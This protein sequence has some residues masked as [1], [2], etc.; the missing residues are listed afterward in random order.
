MRRN[1]RHTQLIASAL[2][3]A[4]SLSFALPMVAQEDEEEEEEIQAKLA[5][6]LSAKLE[7]LDETA[8]D[9]ARAK[10]ERAINLGIGELQTIIDWLGSHAS[11]IERHFDSKGQKDVV[12][13]AEKLG[14]AVKDAQRELGEY[15]AEGSQKSL[16]TALEKVQDLGEAAVGLISPSN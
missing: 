5:N 13:A 16:M 1:R 10:D 12:R 11:K 3:V 15:E 4:L 14:S 8:G 6:D 7:Q 9:L 2:S